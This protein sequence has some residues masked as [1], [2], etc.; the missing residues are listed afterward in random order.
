M[1]AGRQRLGIGGGQLVVADRRGEL[2][3]GG[4]TQAA[5]EVVVEE[6]L[7]G[8]ADVLG[9]GQDRVLA[10]HAQTLV[11]TRVEGTNVR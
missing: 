4:R 2:D 8:S 7:R 1:E 9:R 10:V 5:V 11:P 6:N 3:D